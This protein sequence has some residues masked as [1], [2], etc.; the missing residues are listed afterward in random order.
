MCAA[1]ISIVLQTW[2]F[3][4]A[5]E[6]AIWHF[7]VRIY[8]TCHTKGR[9]GQARPLAYQR[10]LSSCIHIHVCAYVCVSV[11]I[12][13]SLLTQHGQLHG[14]THG[15]V[16]GQS[17][18]LG[19]AGVFRVVIIRAGLQFQTRGGC[20]AF[21]RGLLDLVFPFFCEAESRREEMRLGKRLSDIRGRYKSKWKNNRYYYYY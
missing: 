16:R 17:L 2:P 18:V 8:L 4:P 7:A 13:I 15:H 12:C 6:V 10:P 14:G 20:K 19:L 21:G 5:N 3:E 11:Y 9:P 1:S